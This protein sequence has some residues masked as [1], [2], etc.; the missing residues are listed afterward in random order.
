MTPAELQLAFAARLRDFLADD[1]CPFQ[2][3]WVSDVDPT[4]PPT[5]TVSTM[6]AGHDYTI[7]VQFEDPR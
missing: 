2:L 4:D 1:A 6:W 5:F 7:T 3:A